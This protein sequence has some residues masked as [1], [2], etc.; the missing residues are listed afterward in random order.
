MSLMCVE[1]IDS[2]YSYQFFSALY[3]ECQA[4]NIFSE[5]A[6]LSRHVHFVWMLPGI[7]LHLLIGL[8]Q[9]LAHSGCFAN[10]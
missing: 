10:K 1:F 8:E 6:S 9:P 2:I 5:L 7:L 4:L 3:P